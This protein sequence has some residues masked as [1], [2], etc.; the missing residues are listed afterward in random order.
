MN[1]FKDDFERDETMIDDFFKNQAQF[2]ID[3]ISKKQNRKKLHPDVLKIYN[4]DKEYIIQPVIYEEYLNSFYP[5]Y[6]DT[7][8][9]IANAKHQRESEDKFMK[10]YKGMYRRID[11]KRYSLDETSLFGSIDKSKTIQ[12]KDLKKKLAVIDAYL[13]HQL[14]TVRDLMP[15][16]LVNQ[17]AVNND[18]IEKSS[19]V[20][21]DLIRQ[22]TKELDDLETF[23]LSQREKLRVY[24]ENHN[25]EVNEEILDAI[26]RTHPELFGIY[27]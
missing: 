9:D 10:H 14:V 12:Q 20:V 21:D 5:Y 23:R 1:T 11:M 13:G 8:D 18:F 4:P 24:Y 7:K 22:Q 2:V 16:T 17:W 25:F 6:H 19:E 26:E 27:D 3:E 15:N